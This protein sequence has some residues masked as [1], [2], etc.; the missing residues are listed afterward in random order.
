[1]DTIT[2]SPLAITMA[3]LGGL[4][5]IHK[6][7]SVDDHA[8]H[9]SAVKRFEAGMVVNPLTIAANKTLGDALTLMQQYGISG[10]PVTEPDSPKLGYPNQP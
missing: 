6:N 9:V 7:M 4:G 5:I 1:M 8:K 2:E 10:I 3:Q